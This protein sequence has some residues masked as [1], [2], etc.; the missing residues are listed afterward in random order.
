MHSKEAIRA[1]HPLHG[2]GKP[3]DIVG[4]AIFLASAEA[5]WIT[6]VNLPID[7]GYTAQ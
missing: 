2:T 1:K 5:R 7:G 3:E 4:A 6:G